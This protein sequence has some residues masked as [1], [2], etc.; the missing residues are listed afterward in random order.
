MKLKKTQ[1]DEKCFSDLSTTLCSLRNISYRRQKE[2]QTQTYTEPLK[3]RSN[4]ASYKG[5]KIEGKFVSKNIINIP[6]RDPFTFEVS[7]LSECLK[8]KPT[9]NNMS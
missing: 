6:R 9:Q 5:V 8:F 4:I 2:Q 1:G 3:L 7:L